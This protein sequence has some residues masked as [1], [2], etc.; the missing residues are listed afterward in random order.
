MAEVEYEGEE[1]RFC[2]KTG[3]LT[4]EKMENRMGELTQVLYIPAERNL[5]SIA[6]N[7]KQLKGFPDSLMDFVGEFDRAKQ[8]MKEPTK[9]P[10]N[11]VTIE[12]DR[13]NDIVNIRGKGY[14]VRLTESSSG[15]Q[16]SVP[17]FMVSNYYANLVKREAVAGNNNMSLEEKERFSKEAENIWNTEGIS[18][19]MRRVLLSKLAQ[20][21]NKSAFINIVEELEQNLF[22]T[23]QRELLYSLLEFNNYN[24]GNK[25]ILTSH[26]PYIVMYLTLCV[27]AERINSKLGMQEKVKEKLKEIIPQ[28]AMIEG[29]QLAIYELNDQEGTIEKLKTYRGLPSDENKLNDGLEE[30]NERF[31][32]LLEL[33]ELCQ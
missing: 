32:R 26:S 16:A 29:E 33:E 31:S 13:L 22:P 10:I 5:A 21:F 17:L 12:Y 28:G 19:E 9:L 8:E 14:R 11:Q 25:L 30:A 2:Y 24:R 3:E 18:D 7:A 23:S 4:I 15:F 1:Y 27:E 6:K 20:K